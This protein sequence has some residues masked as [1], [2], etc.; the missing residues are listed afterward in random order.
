MRERIRA[1][2]REAFADLYEEHARGV[3]N[4]A[5]RLTGDWSTAEEVV[6]DTFLEAWRSREKVEPHG[7]SLRPWLWGIATNKARNTNR[8]LRRRIAFLARRPATEK[9][10]DFADESVSRLDSGRELDA[11]RQA[12]TLLR[13][14][15]R[16]VLA[17]CVPPHCV[18]IIEESRH[19]NGCGPR[20]Q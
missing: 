14:P 18:L 6:S 13:R 5:F 16:E 8:G 7:W 19:E 12:L 20:N 17:L 11:V 4:H 2:D 1:G 9:A 10:A 3:Y 15:E